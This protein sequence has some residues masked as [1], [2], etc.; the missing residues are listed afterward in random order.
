MFLDLLLSLDMDV[1]VY[2][3]IIP[4]LILEF[5]LMVYINWN[6]MIILL[7]LYLMFS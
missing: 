1:S 6:L 3:R 4:L 2:V 7:N 5:L